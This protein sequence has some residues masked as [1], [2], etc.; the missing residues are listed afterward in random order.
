[1]SAAA[2]R[3]AKASAAAYVENLRKQHRSAKLVAALDAP[4]DAAAIQ[5][6]EREGVEKERERERERER[7]GQQAWGDGVLVGCGGGGSTLLCTLRTLCFSR[8][9]NSVPICTL[10][11]TNI[12]IL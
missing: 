9:L 12:S 7:E 1:M 2:V 11:D 4:P 10:G 5:V 8:C 6:S 3:E